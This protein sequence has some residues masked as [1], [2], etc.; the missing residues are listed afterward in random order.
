MF[1]GVAIGAGWQV[2]VAYLSVGCYFL[3]GVPFGALMAYKFEMGLKVYNVKEMVEFISIECE[4]QICMF[5][6]EFLLGTL[7]WDAAWFVPANWAIAVDDM[8]CKLEQRG[9]FYMIWIAKGRT[10]I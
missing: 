4:Y 10:L 3:F 9:E 8:D 7:V 2:R 1:V 6:F 5:N